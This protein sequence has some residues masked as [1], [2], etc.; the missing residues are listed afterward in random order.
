MRTKNIALGVIVA[1]L[2]LWSVVY[3]FRDALATRGLAL[4]VDNVPAV[5]CNHARVHISASLR[6]IIVSPLDCQIQGKPMRR[7]QTHDDLVV[8]LGAVGVDDVHVKRATVDYNERDLSHV[9]SNTL[10]DIAALAGVS[11]K[12]VK[13]LLDAS[14]NY[15]D[16]SPPLRVDV[17]TMQRGG[18]TSAVMHDFSK[19][20]DGAW[21]RTYAARVESGP[22][23]IR[24][25]DMRATPS[26]GRLT[27][28]VYLGSA[29]RDEKPDVPLVLEAEQLD[30]KQPRITLHL[31]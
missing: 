13:S 10:G 21:E 18:K 2:L 5:Q 25:F 30:A 12:L 22:I 1:I 26:R 17:L 31:R 6:R 11:D 27:G 14:E 24:Q 3:V 8:T 28:N 16:S 29:N 7:L 9:Q 15:S 19:S 20:P 4:V 23:E